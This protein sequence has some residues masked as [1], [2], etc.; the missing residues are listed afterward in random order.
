MVHDPAESDLNNNIINYHADH[1]NCHTCTWNPTLVKM[2]TLLDKWS[3]NAIVPVAE[4]TLTQ[5]E[6]HA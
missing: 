3:T 1:L 5:I 2:N 4:W 6:K